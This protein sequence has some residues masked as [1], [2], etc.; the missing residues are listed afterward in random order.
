MEQRQRSRGVNRG[1]GA[2]F[3]VDELRDLRLQGA[4]VGESH[5]SGTGLQAQLVIGEADVLFELPTAAGLVE[6]EIFSDLAV[7]VGEPESLL[8]VAMHGAVHL[9]QLVDHA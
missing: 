4:Y 2:E 7:A 6:Q 1:G 5:R 3:P 8:I 9:F